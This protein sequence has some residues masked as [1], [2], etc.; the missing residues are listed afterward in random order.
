MKYILVV[1]GV[2]FAVVAQ[3]LLK[4]ASS[5]VFFEKR[6]LTFLFLSAAAYGLAFFTQSYMFKYFALSK[7]APATS[8]AIMI[9]V[10]VCGVWLFNETIQ[11]KQIIGILLGIVSIYLIL[12]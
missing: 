6:W 1:S 9:L 11:L 12:G 4:I 10:F 2:V 3:I 7:I 8:I 5:N